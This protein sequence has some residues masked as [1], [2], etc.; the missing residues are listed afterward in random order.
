LAAGFS[1]PDF[2]GINL[3]AMDRPLSMSLGQKSPVDSILP[4]SSPCSIEGCRHSAWDAD[5]GRKSLKTCRDDKKNRPSPSEPT[6]DGQCQKSLFSVGMAASSRQLRGNLMDEQH[7]PFAEKEDGLGAGL[8]ELVDKL[9]GQGTSPDEV[10]A[11]IEEL[12]PGVLPKLGAIFV[13]GL[14]EQAPEMFQDRAALRDRFSRRLR[15]C[16]LNALF[17]SAA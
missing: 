3:V 1:P 9:L 13:D 7:S 10:A 5:D 14:K 11:K 6:N 16:E 8:S 2:L 15:V 12:L 4:V 17:C